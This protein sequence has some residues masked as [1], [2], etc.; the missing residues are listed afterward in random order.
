VYLG[1]SAWHG[2]VV[3]PVAA[4]LPIDEPSFEQDP[5]VMADRWLGESER[6]SQMADA[7]LTGRLSLDQAENTKTAWIGQDAQQCRQ[8]TG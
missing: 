6:I 3:H 8:P 4:P 7:S 2:A 5:Q 1:P